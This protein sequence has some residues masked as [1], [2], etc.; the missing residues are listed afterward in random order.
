MD[1][2]TFLPFARKGLGGVFDL[3]VG[4]R[5]EERNGMIYHEGRPVCKTRSSAGKNCFARDDDGH[6][7]E[8]GALTT[9]IREALARPDED[10]QARWDKVW[11]DDVC[12]AYRRPDQP[13]GVWLWSDE[14]YALDMEPL[15][16]IADLVGAR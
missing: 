10:H 7:L 12:Q 15:G 1:Y 16:H 5:V 8:R 14:F 4:D 2:I 9:D 13:E 3:S 11:A 6:G